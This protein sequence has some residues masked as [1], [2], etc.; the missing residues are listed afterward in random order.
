[1]TRR[2]T[3]SVRDMMQLGLDELN[4]VARQFSGNT[5]QAVGNMTQENC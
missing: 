3:V 1:M 2:I 4:A 5:L